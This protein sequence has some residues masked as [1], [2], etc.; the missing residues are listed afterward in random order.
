MCAECASQ[1]GLSLEKDLLK[2]KPKIQ[3]EVTLWTAM[4]KTIA[5]FIEFH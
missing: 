1:K 5:D 3:S 2:I 4:S